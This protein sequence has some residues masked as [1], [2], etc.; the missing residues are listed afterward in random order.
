MNGKVN[1]HICAF[2]LTLGK[3]LNHSE[4]NC[5]T[6]SNNPKNEQAAAHR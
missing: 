1:R 6:K 3:Q 2:C 5:N 4:K